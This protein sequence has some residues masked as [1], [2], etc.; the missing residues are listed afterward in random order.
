MRHRGLV[1]LSGFD[2]LRVGRL[3]RFLVEAG[4]NGGGIN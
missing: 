1:A 3:I 4:R 2:S